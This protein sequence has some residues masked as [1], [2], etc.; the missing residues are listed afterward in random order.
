MNTTDLSSLSTLQL[1]ELEGSVDGVLCVVAKVST[2]K[3]SAKVEER[4]R[5]VITAAWQGVASKTL[6]SALS[7]LRKGPYTQKRINAF[8]AKFGLKLKDPLTREQII[9]I[10]KRVDEIY[11]IAKR[12]GAKEAKFKPV[13]DLVD[14]RAVRAINKQ[15]VFWVG[16][17]YSDKLSARIQAVSNDVL[18]NQ[19]LSHGEAAEELGKALRQELGLVEG[20]TDATKYAPKL[21]ARYAG[22]SELYLRQVASTAAHQART[23]GRLTAYQQGGIK[24]MRIT[25]PNDDRTGR[26]CRAMVGQIITVAA[27]VNQMNQ[28]LSAKT[29]KAVKAVAPWL[30]GKQVEGI[31]GGAKVGSPA[32][33]RSLESSDATLIPPYHSLCRSEL[34]VVD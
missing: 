25:N 26:V 30:T 1:L 4:M 3:E 34:I 21:P 10:E 7:T 5:K 17:F 6:T 20:V 31:I 11:R 13:F 18:L 22:K 8:L 14:R 19:G 33:T 27:G 16:D 2:V 15:Q 32:A 23:F 9:F 12:I 28:I 29:P 24:R